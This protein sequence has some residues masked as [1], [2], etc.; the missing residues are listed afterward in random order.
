MKLSMQADQNVELRFS[1]VVPG[2]EGVG[3]LTFPLLREIFKPRGPQYEALS[4]SLKAEFKEIDD[5]LKKQAVPTV[6]SV[7]DLIDKSKI[8]PYG[9]LSAYKLLRRVNTRWPEL[10]GTIE[11]QKQ[12]ASALYATKSFVDASAQMAYETSL[13]GIV[14]DA[15]RETIKD[16]WKAAKTG[17]QLM[18]FLV[19]ALPFVIGGCVITAGYL[20]YRILKSEAGKQVITEFTPLPARLALRALQDRR[21]QGRVGFEID[22]PKNEYA[23]SG[24]SVNRDTFWAACPARI[25]VPLYERSFIGHLAARGEFVMVVRWNKFATLEWN[26]TLKLW[27]V[28]GFGRRDDN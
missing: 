15:F 13:F 26:D 28:T 8:G 7:K 4:P 12:I 6:K 5:Y 20:V 23:I 24:R 18:A 11:G 14:K 16:V 19:K 17:F 27:I 25:P 9:K 3:F 10:S 1:D 22:R 2:S 21:R